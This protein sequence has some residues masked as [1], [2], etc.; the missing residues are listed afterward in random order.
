MGSR[1]T[2]LHRGGYQIISLLGDGSLEL[3]RDGQLFEGLLAP[4]VARNDLLFGNALA[5]RGW[6]HRFPWVVDRGWWPGGCAQTPELRASG[7]KAPGLSYNTTPCAPV[8]RRRQRRRECQGNRRSSRPAPRARSASPPRA[9]RKERGGGPA[10]GARR[11]SP[12]LLAGDPLGSRSR[13]TRWPRSKP[14]ESP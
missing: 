11:S 3:R 5:G 14:S 9:P 12:K 8:G 13:R 2:D 6:I 7:L 4:V 1:T 10:R